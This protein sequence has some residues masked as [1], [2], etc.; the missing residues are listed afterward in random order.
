MYELTTEELTQLGAVIT[1]NEIKQQPEL[2][3]EA[4]ENYRSKENEINRFLTDLSNQFQQIRVIFTGAGTSAYVGDT[5]LPYLKGQLNGK[6]WD[7]MSIPTTDLVS[8]P[9]SFFANEIP[10][11]LVSFARSG[12]SPE[13]LAAVSLGKQL[14]KDFYQLTITCAFDG[15]LA[16]QAEGDAKNL[17]LLMPKKANDKGFAM[18]G[19]YSCMTLTALLVFDLT[20]LSQ[21]ATWIEQ[22]KVMGEDVLQR[23]TEIQKI[24]DLDFNRVIYLGSG[25]LAGMTREAQL[26]ILELT[27]G[28]ITTIFDSSLGFRH[29]PKSFV[30]EQ[31]LVFVF[32]SNDPYTRQYDLDILNELKQ[33]QIACYVSGLS[34]AGET[35]YGGNNFTLLGNGK[36]L[37]DAYLV[38]PYIIF[39][40]TVAVLSAIKVGNQPDTPSPTGTVN[41]VVKGVEI[42]PYQVD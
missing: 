30:N 18:T 34:V 13:S 26:K 5:V 32:T 41:R 40:Q 27:A 25:S 8:N 19:S 9:E 12:N 6:K 23:S 14:V 39:A 31:T 1:A 20:S 22:L 29:G 10:T 21:K 28:Q 17:L 38:L 3:Q 2:W 42:H 11:L 36:D 33:D 37:P 16:N 4:F 15:K 7:L 35:N 24:I